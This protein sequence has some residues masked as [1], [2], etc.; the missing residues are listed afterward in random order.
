M[1]IKCPPTFTKGKS[2]SS[3]V[4]IFATALDVTMSNDSLSSPLAASSALPWI[5]SIPLIQSL[6]LPLLRK[7]FS[8]LT[9]QVVSLQFQ[10][11]KS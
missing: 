4:L 1:Q 11:Y 7:L 3:S 2:Y 8:C 9:S 6:L 5:A 10:D